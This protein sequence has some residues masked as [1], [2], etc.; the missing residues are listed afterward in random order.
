[1]IKWFNGQI[2]EEK[3]DCSNQDEIEK[4]SFKRIVLAFTKKVRIEMQNTR[5]LF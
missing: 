2:K 5:N 4:L 1:M 3:F